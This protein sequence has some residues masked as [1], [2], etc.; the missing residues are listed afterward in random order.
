VI[1][2][3]ASFALR[4]QREGGNGVDAKEPS[5]PTKISLTS[6]D[7]RDLGVVG[8]WTFIGLTLT[9][10]FVFG[11]AVELGQALAITG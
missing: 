10:F 4:R 3:A 9:A 8:I 6:A 1:G 2:S 7:V 5:M 11:F